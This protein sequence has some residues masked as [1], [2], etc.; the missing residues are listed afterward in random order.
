LN[1]LFSINSVNFDLGTL[2]WEALKMLLN[3]PF[4]P[5][6]HG[7]PKSELA[8]TPLLHPPPPPQLLLY[9]RLSVQSAGSPAMMTLSRAILVSA[10]SDCASLSYVARADDGDCTA[11]MRMSRRAT[12]CAGSL[13]HPGVRRWSSSP[14][15]SSTSCPTC[16][17][18]SRPTASTRRSR[19]QGLL[20]TLEVVSD[21]QPL[22]ALRVL[23]II[24][25]INIVHPDTQH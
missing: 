25:P 12:A 20:G 3:L 8:W 2:F 11:R 16:S 10:R 17:R 6:F 18:S 5:P 23:T 15:A 14:W 4:Q 24:E 13:L 22:P 1:N 19:A 7:P 21:C 9:A